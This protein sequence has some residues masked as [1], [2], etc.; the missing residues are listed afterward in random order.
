MPPHGKCRVCGAPA[1]GNMP[2]YR[3]AGLL[4]ERDKNSRFVFGTAQGADTYG[5]NPMN[6]ESL[7]KKWERMGRSYTRAAEQLADELEMERAE[8]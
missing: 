6:K 4:L 1:P 3:C 2:C 7:I 5:G 8:Q